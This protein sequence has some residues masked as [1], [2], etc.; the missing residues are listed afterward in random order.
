MLD[1]VNKLLVKSN[2]VVSF[3]YSSSDVFIG[4]ITEFRM[5]FNMNKLSTCFDGL[6]SNKKLVLTYAPK[7][8]ARCVL[9]MHS[10]NLLVCASTNLLVQ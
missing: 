4:D 6:I 1:K 2:F 7:K 10:Q 3:F 8:K 9:H 5:E